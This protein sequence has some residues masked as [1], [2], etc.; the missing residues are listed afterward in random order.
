MVCTVARGGGRLL[1][2][3]GEK[4]ILRVVVYLSEKFGVG[5]GKKNHDIL[6]IFRSGA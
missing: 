6:G 2:E 5:C 3:H 1:S 4:K